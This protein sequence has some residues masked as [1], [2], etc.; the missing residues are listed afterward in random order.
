MA[1][2]LKPPKPFIDVQG[3]C[4]S[5]FLAGSI[6]MGKA[7]DWQTKVWKELKDIPG[8]AVLNPRRDNWDSSWK[9]E[10]TNKKF[11]EQVEW[12]LSGL[13]SVDLV[14]FYFDPKTQSPIT[15]CELGILSHKLSNFSPKTI[16]CC[17]KGF[18]R[19][20]NVDIVCERYG[21]TTVDTLDE[22]ILGIKK[23][24][25]HLNDI[26]ENFDLENCKIGWT[27]ASKKG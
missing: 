11:K 12:E 22:L 4:S 1:K 3:V 10:I 16:V 18:H 25:E 26:D 19:K 2:L 7:E 5:V 15:L 27:K 14:A 6:E 20:G 13:E 9:Q 23:E 21:H 17:P 8:L 24:F